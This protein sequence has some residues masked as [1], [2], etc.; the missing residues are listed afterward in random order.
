MARRYDSKGNP[1]KPKKEHF[2][3]LP[4]RIMET[5]AWRALSPNAQ[6]L[7]PWFLLE[8]KGTD[9]NNNGKIR[10]SVRQAARALGVTPDTAARAIRDLQ[11][12]GFV[13]MKE[14]ACLGIEGAGKSPAFELTDIPLPGS[15]KPEGRKAF[16]EWR[17]GQE[18][19]VPKVASNNPEGR[20][21]RAKPR[22]EKQHT[23]V[24]IVRTV[25]K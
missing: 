6:A 13:A 3:R 15:G 17:P 2:A 8:W 11:A 25:G 1:A 14:P 4:R 23:S 19:S 21:G 10:M 18:L 12:K 5:P 22:H 16:N 24:T 20:N 9:F 7:Y